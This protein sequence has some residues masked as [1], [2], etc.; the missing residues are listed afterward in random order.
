[1]VRRWRPILQE[2]CEAAFLLIEFLC[3]KSRR[4]A[5]QSREQLI[6]M[7][8]LLEPPPEKK[9]KSRALAITVV[10]LVA[11]LVVVLWLA[12]RYYPEKK[13][14]GEFFDAL[15]AGDTDRA[16]A[17]WK[18][19]PSYRKDDFLADWG[20]GGYYGPVRSYKIM[21]ART[22]R[23]SDSVAINVAISP[24]APMPDAS[25]AEKSRKTRVVTL[26]ITPSDK[27][28]SFPP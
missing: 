2:V 5:G 25:D 13:V 16:Y 26:W 22:P 17:L 27:S 1:L 21:D 12:F 7:M 6:A 11:A 9:D 14:A 23:K 3:R 18:P 19:T 24:Y 10:A 8:S 4:A 15:V 28:F 20:A